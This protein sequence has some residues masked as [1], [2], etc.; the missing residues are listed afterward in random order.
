MVHQT[1]Q[2]FRPDFIE[3]TQFPPKG[4]DLV[5]LSV[6]TSHYFSPNNNFFFNIHVKG[7]PMFLTFDP[8]RD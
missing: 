2:L 1:R 8:Y 5:T 3:I 4:K 7:D 6:Y